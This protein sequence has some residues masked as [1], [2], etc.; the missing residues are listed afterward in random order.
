MTII[1]LL[2][3]NS[4]AL[5]PLQMMIENHDEWTY[6]S[7][8]SADAIAKNSLPQG[9]AEQTGIQDYLIVPWEIA[10]TP[11]EA[12]KPRAHLGVCFPNDGDLSL[13]AGCL[14]RFQLIVLDFP[15]FTD[16]RSYSIA[17][18]L[19]QIYAYQ[20]ELRAR[21]DILMDQLHFMWRC[22][23]DSLEVKNVKLANDI[24]NH[25]LPFTDFYQHAA[26]G[27]EPVYRMR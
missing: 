10:K 26:Q 8:A 3:Q 20:G 13:L 18:T 14:D 19:K 23:F 25:P 15:S 2:N 12:W 24:I 11:S 17:S 4:S 22:G 7:E 16:G 21:G 1:R 5:N 6:L 27:G 9:L